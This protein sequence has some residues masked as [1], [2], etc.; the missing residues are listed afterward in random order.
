MTRS[1]EVWYADLMSGP[2]QAK[3]RTPF[4]GRWYDNTYQIA[5]AYGCTHTHV[6]QMLRQLQKVRATHGVDAARLLEKASALRWEYRHRY[7]PVTWRR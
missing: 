2:P 3:D 1:S 5:E 6:M 7:G 4:G